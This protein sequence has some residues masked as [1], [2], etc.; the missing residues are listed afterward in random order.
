MIRSFR[1]LGASAP[2]KPPMMPLFR[3]ANDPPVKRRP[4][5]T[6]DL[7]IGHWPVAYEPS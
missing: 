5:K 1:E 7:I 4:I 3:G 2:E 6:P